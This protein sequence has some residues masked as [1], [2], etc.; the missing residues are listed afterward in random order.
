[1]PLLQPSTH[2]PARSSQQRQFDMLPLLRL[3]ST[4]EKSRL[5]V[6]SCKLRTRT[7][8]SPCPAS[9]HTGRRSGG[10]KD[11]AIEASD[12]AATRLSTFCAEGM[13][14]T[15]QRLAPVLGF[16]GLQDS[17]FYQQVAKHHATSL[18]TSIGQ[19]GWKEHW[20]DLSS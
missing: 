13:P 10:N 19:A 12:L 17:R 8:I 18:V 3:W 11:G 2:I 14:G 4:Y 9:C 5:M 6:S 20:N 1:M 7:S 15:S 16:T